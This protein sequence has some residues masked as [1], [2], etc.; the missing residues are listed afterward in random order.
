MRKPCLTGVF[1]GTG[2]REV[3]E[4]EPDRSCFLP[5]IS[6]RLAR[7]RRGRAPES[8]PAAPSSTSF[9]HTYRGS[10]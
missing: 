7:Y 5:G 8:L 10:G 9:V 1:R 2:V 3:P 6:K 4:L